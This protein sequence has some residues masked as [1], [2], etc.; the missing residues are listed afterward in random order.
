[1]HYFIFEK[2]LGIY[3]K[4]QRNYSGL[5]YVRNFTSC[6]RQVD[7]GEA[8]LALITNEVTM[9]QVKRVCHSG[10]VMP[11]KSTFFYPKVIGGFLFSSIK[12]HEFT[13][14]AAACL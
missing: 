13:T 10:A 11:Q 4:A 1:M 7:T 2:I 9:D 5:S 6:I 12:E 8:R 3:R 14:S